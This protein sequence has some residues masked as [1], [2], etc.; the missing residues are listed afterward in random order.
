MDDLDFQVEPLDINIAKMQFNMVQNF[1]SDNIN[2]PL[3]ER[4]ENH[5]PT[6]KISEVSVECK[7]EEKDNFILEVEVSD[8]KKDKKYFYTLKSGNKQEISDF[9]NDR[10]FLFSIKE[11]VLTINEET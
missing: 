2:F 6:L 10:N 9:L 1:A 7:K 5:D 3:S 11:L 4:F 8:S